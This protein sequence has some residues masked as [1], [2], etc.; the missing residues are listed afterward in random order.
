MYN[1]STF[2]LTI[3]TATVVV[4]LGSIKPSA[5]AFSTTPKA[6]APSCFPVI[7]KAYVGK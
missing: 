4:V 7:K 2:R 1:A 5:S 6:P 3:F